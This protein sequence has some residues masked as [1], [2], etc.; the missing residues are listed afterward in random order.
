MAKLLEEC[1]V[2]VDCQEET[3]LKYGSPS[4]IPDIAARMGYGCHRAWEESLCRQ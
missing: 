3:I 1:S 4:L 2:P